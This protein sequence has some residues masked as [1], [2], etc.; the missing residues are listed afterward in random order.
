VKSDRLLALLLALQHAGKQSATA[1]AEQLEVSVRTIYRD[2]DALSAAGVPVY[3]ERGSRGGIVLA[4]TYRD[5]LARFDE[6]EVRALFVSSDDALADI[7]LLGGHRSALDKLARAMP[8]RT[9]EQLG[10]T[11]GRVH[12]DGR[13]W[14]GVSAPSAALATLREAVWNDRWVTIAYTDRGGKVTR[15]TLEPF[16]LVTK[17]GIWYLIARD[18]GTVKTFRVQRVARARM[19]ERR[20]TR[21]STF[22]AGEYWKGVASH[23]AREDEPYLATFRM[24]RRGLANASLYFK[25]ESQTRVRNARRA[26]WIVR[27]KF[28]LFEAALHEA[29]SWQEDG[30]AIEPPE[31]CRRIHAHASALAKLY[32]HPELVEGQPPS[33]VSA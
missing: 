12:V 5:T 10:A 1:L 7:G 14:I 30:I 24:T 3:A 31:L 29:I 22:D 8:A 13:R 23:V 27:I 4:D 28:P 19:L 11:R 33:A 21:P 20:F 9:R 2:T 26:E 18:R 17:A 15:R 16:G 32:C 6:N 25:V